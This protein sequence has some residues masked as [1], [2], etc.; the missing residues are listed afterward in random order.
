MSASD[1]EIFSPAAGHSLLRRR[2]PRWAAGLLALLVALAAPFSAM[3]SPFL[4]FDARTGEVLDENDAFAP[5]YP[6]SITKLMTAYVAFE[7]MRAGEVTPRSPVTISARALAEPPSKMGFKAGTVLTLDAALKMMIV[8]SAND[9]AVA[10]AESISGS[11]PAFIAR[12]NETSRR[13]GMTG[14]RWTNPNGLPD[15]GQWSTARDLGILTRALIVGFP[16]HAE[17]FRITAFSVGRQI[18]RSHNDLLERYPGS[19]GM[20]TGYICSSGFNVVASATRDGRRIVAVVLGEPNSAYRSEKTAQLIEKAFGNRGGLFG[21]R[22]KLET[23]RPSQTPAAAP[24]DMR[25]YVCGEGREEA[26]KIKA[27]GPSLLLPRSPTV[28]AVALSLGG[29]EGPV[30][31]VAE[32]GTGSGDELAISDHLTAYA[33]SGPGIVPLPPLRPL[34]FA[35]IDPSATADAFDPAAAQPRPRP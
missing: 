18:V 35:T 19:D 22:Q 7:A 29:A 31:V 21:G 25:P 33:A 2:A 3:A 10:I 1:F 23:L 27:P 28:T 9:V 12:M 13:L 15:P 4:V 16:E 5:W 11:E 14:S 17:M 8:K 20:K 32:A 26:R 30:G 24:F 34:P 6:A